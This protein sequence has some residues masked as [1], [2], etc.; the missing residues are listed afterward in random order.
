MIEPE[1]IV[2]LSQ[3]VKRLTDRGVNDIQRIT[4][5]TRLLGINALI[6]AAHAGTAG[7][8]FAVVAEEVRAISE[9]IT[10][11]AFAMT[12]ELQS[13]VD[14]LSELGRMMCFDVRGQRLAD[15]SLNMIEIIDRNLYERSCDVRW[16]A[17]DPSFS[18]ALQQRSST[19]Y[20]EANKRLSIIL[21]SYTVYLDIWLIDLHG[22]VVATGRSDVYPYIIGSNV[23][24]AD[25][26][27]AAMKLRNSDSYSVGDVLRV[28][29]SLG[30][31]RACVFGAP[32]FGGPQ[33]TDRTGT[34]AVLFDWQNQA[35][36]VLEGVRLS[37]EERSRSRL[38]IVDDHYRILASSDP[39]AVWGE[40]ISLDPQPRS[41]TGY[42][43]LDSKTLQAFARTPGFE[44]YKGLGWYGVIEQCLPN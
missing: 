2:G 43:S 17:T 7:R 18:D 31:A 26:F 34:L 42:R 23:S 13:T 14:E 9:R 10:D 27:R 11:I 16:W 1:R 20:E 28:E 32:V 25:W 22:E 44:T 30:D 37:E 39:K 3:E 19:C 24:Q 38:L 15:L 6:E 4:H 41:L 8:G 35:R 33:G 12:K 29:S 36:T 40:R 21:R 5:Q